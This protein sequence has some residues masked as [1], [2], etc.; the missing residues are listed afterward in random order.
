M[1][2][3]KLIGYILLVIFT[4]FVAW[5]GVKRI[6]RGIRILRQPNRSQQYTLNYFWKSTGDTHGFGLMDILV[7]LGCVGIS[8]IV[9]VMIIKELIALYL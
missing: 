8:I 5:Y 1:D 3:N 6:I 4:P 2:T 7:G 9:F